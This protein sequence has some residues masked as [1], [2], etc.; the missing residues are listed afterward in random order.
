[1]SGE[2]A[3]ASCDLHAGALRLA[4]R[5]DLG[6]AIAGLWLDGL[7]VLRSTEPDRLASARA[8]ACYPLVP[9]SN[10]LGDRRFRW[11]GRSYEVAANVDDESHA[12]HGVGWQRRWAVK[13]KTDTG[14]AL[15]L[16]H[17]GDD[18][19]PFA[20]HVEQLFELTP[21]SLQLTLTATNIDARIGPMGLGWHPYFPRRERSRI[22][23]EASARW[24]TDAA[25][26]PVRSVAQPGIDADVAVL[27][28]DHC[29]DGW[30]GE[31]RVRD[32]RLS[33]RLASSLER[34]VVYTPRDK[35][36]FCVE[37]V[38]HVNNAIHMAEP[39]RHGLVALAPGQTLDAW[40]RLTVAR[41]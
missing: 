33:L 36:Y 23:L 2:S 34:A 31:A 38:S 9:Y 26:L 21:Q 25:R 37:P 16:T 32:E 40:M 11:K 30:R 4:L 14:V 39:A 10:R 24:E 6:G 29:F 41:A 12:L 5:P 17:A 28:F 1:M 15:E 19:W 35:P 8:A 20:F 7:P 27:D 3:Q 18:H 13:H 22:H